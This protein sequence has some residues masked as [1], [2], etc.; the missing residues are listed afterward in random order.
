METMHLHYVKSYGN[1][2][3]YPNCTKSSA[4]LVL[5]KAKSFTEQNVEILRK[6]WTVQIATVIPANSK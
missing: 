6:H 2:R 5:M 4:I 3:Y 1:D